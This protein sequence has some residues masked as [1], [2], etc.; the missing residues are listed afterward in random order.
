LEKQV[1]PWFEILSPTGSTLLRQGPSN[2]WKTSSSSVGEAALRSDAKDTKSLGEALSSMLEEA[3]RLSDLVDALLLL[4]RTD[5]G[6]F[7]PSL[8]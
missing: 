4:A 3:R 6:G 2:N 7:S 8:D 1:G 5:T